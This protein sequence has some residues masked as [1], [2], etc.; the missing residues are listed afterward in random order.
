MPLQPV[1]FEQLVLPH[2]DSAYNL[3][4]W[5]AGSA[6]SA[7]DIV[8]EALLRALQ[9]QDSLRGEPK[10]WLLRIVR[11]VAYAMMTANRRGADV[12]LDDVPYA[13]KFDCI[14]QSDTPEM[15]LHSREQSQALDRAVAALPDELRECLILRELEDMTYKEIAHVTGV[16]IG[17]VMSRLF[18]ARRLMLGAAL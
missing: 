17:T 15:A 11:N 16:P 2:L 3:A 9:Y 10:P 6:V 8:Q 7:D 4:R 5:L 13:G 14:D 12:S 18:R 1:P